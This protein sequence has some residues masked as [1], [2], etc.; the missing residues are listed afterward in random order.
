MLKSL[1]IQNYALISRLEIDFS[2]GLS[3]ITGETGAGKSIIV[4]ALSLILGQ[5]ADAKSI[6]QG[7]DKCSIEG[8]FDISSYEGLQSFFFERELDYDTQNCILRR[9]IWSSG[10]SRAFIND[11]PVNLNDLKDLGAF[12]IDIHSQHQNL[13]LSNNRFQLQVVDVL[14]GN[15]NL[16]DK[17]KDEYQNFLSIR[18]RLQEL[19]EK[20]K[21]HSSEQD[22]LRFQFQQL[23]DAKLKER[24]QTELEKESETLIHIEEIKNG[25]HRIEHLLSDDEQGIVVAL[26]Y[27]LNTA[28]S[29]SKIYRSSD[30]IAE[31]LQTAYLDLKD[32]MLEVNAQQEKLE[33]DPE[34]LQWINERLDLLYSL[35]QKHKLNSIESLIALRN[36]FE[37]QLQAI[38]S[39]DE[40]I[41]KLQQQLSVSQN[42]M[43]QLAKELSETRKAAAVYLEKQLVEKVSVLGMPYMQ[44]SC[45]IAGK[46][47]PDST[48]LDDVNFFFSANKNVE[49]KPVAQTASGGEISRLMLGIKALIAGATALPTI[50][51]DEIDA[52]VSGE[53]ADKMG[54][55]MHQMGNVMQ[56]IVIT[57]LPQIAA[58]GDIQFFVYKDEN[59]LLTETHIRQLS[60]EERIKEIAQMLSGIKLTE[61]AIENAKELL[62]K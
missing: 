57:H 53:I 29:I 37:I 45:R 31:R 60:E 18:K 47:F 9:E 46:E 33:L 34:R 42:K 11:T 39:Y 52:G 43:L 26:K 28:Q 41:E 3:V 56:V 32:L 13:L 10:K 40:A 19:Q 61:A 62:K 51:F 1:T 44:F 8:L 6:K 5:R 23:K 38:E 24:E 7:E 49:L 2:K 16:M 21:T 35:Q 30:E 48:G 50:I 36:Q 25:L 20:A 22:Y 17:Y 14:A 27:A 58:R 55:I 4:G 12:L 54:G 59:N 15:K